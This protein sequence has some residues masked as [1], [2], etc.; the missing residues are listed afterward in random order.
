MPFVAYGLTWDGPKAEVETFTPNDY[1]CWPVW[2]GMAD[3]M[4]SV[5]P[6]IQELSEVAHV[7]INAF[8]Q[9]FYRL[10]RAGLGTI[11]YETAAGSRIIDVQPN[12][13]TRYA[14]AATG[15]FQAESEANDPGQGRS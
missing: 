4:R 3:S 14:E 13:S 12:Y 11:V 6:S 8:Y 2:I 1:K 15:E 5:F 10:H 7:G 9:F